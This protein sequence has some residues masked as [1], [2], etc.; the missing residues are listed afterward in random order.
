MPTRR[1]P[2]PSNRAAKRRG[3]LCVKSAAREQ[4]TSPKA[5]CRVAGEWYS[6]TPYRGNRAKSLPPR[7]KKGDQPS[8]IRFAGFFQGAEKGVV[9]MPSHASEKKSRTTYNR[10]NVPYDQVNWPGCYVCN[11]TGNLYRVPDDSLAAGR[12]PLI[13]IVS[14]TPMMMT[15]IS[16]DPWLPIS[17]ARQLAADA[18]LYINF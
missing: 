18:D 17:K 5:H 2:T 7:T 6:E 3:G 8:A 15:R 16:D 13:A 14:K 4:F 10:E 12:S 9:E 1:L 11:D